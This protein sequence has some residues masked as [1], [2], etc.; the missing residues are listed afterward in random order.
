MAEGNIPK[1]AVTQTSNAPSDAAFV[2]SLIG[3]VLITIGSVVGI[4]LGTLGSPS[5]GEWVVLWENKE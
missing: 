2:L 4:R 3:G 5:S 1:P